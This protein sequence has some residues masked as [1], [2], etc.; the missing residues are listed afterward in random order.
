[1]TVSFLTDA[2]CCKQDDHPGLLQPISE[3]LLFCF[4]NLL[5]KIV[6]CVAMA[7]DATAFT[8]QT[9]PDG[10]CW[11]GIFEEAPLP[12]D[13][14][15]YQN[16]PY[17][18][19]SLY[20]NFTLKL[21]ISFIWALCVC[22]FGRRTVR[23]IFTKKHR[24]LSVWGSCLLR[25]Q[26]RSIF[27]DIKATDIII[28][29]VFMFMSSYE[30]S[31]HCKEVI[32]S[33][34]YCFQFHGFSHSVYWPGRLVPNSFYNYDFLHLRIVLSARS[35]ELIL[36]SCTVYRGLSSLFTN[37]FLVHIW[38]LFFPNFWWR[39]LKSSCRALAKTLQN[40]SKVF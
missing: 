6:V 30:R 1:M 13:Q 27:R 9:H 33:T 20:P 24:V 12:L 37:C 28:W 14:Y 18:V 26:L 31:P 36:E 34:L 38:L 16:I 15:F 7:S 11:T 5:L 2:K 29:N 25:T 17:H 39:N 21:I 32:F 10:Q 40:C 4:T 35:K 8:C 22:L 19:P 3:P 23:L